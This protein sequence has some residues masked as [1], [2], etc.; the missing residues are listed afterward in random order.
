MIRALIREMLLEDLEGFVNRTKDISYYSS[1]DLPTFDEPHQKN[2]RSMAK[3]VKRAWALE[4]DHEFMKSLIKVHWG[5]RKSLEK[6]LQIS[7]RNEISTSAYLPGAIVRSFWGSIG[8]VIEGRVTLAANDMNIISSGYFGELSSEIQKKY[9]SS[10]IPKRATIFRGNDRLGA[11]DSFILDR[12]SYAPTKSSRNEFIVDNWKPVGFVVSSLGF[13]ENIE[14]SL[15]NPDAPLYHNAVFVLQHSLPV[16]N[17]RM[18][19]I[20]RSS[21]EAEVEK[22]KKVYGVKF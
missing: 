3:A 12:N 17:Q 13:P 15:L 9:A 4:A 1:I 22:V 18:E 20:P 16:Y 11:K 14:D 10:G 7:R 5:D 19:E 2:H 6:F 8:V 21:I